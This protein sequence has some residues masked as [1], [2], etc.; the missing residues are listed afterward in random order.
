MLKNEILKEEDQY[1]NTK[2]N[3]RK[4]L[5]TTYFQGELET[6]IF[7]LIQE[8][9]CIELVTKS[10]FFFQTLIKLCQHLRECHQQAKIRTSVLHLQ[11]NQRVDYKLQSQ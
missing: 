5:N 1:T 8:S 7:Q 4:G 3:R 2:I 10:L 9:H 6:N 11:H